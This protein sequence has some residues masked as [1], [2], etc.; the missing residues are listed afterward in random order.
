M[1][2][3]NSRRRCRRHKMPKRSEE[4]RASDLLFCSNLFLR[5]YSYREI[6]QKLNEENARNGM[7]YTISMQ[8][9]HWD[10]QQMLIEWKRERM[11]NIDDY[12]TQELRKLDKMEAELWESWERSKNVKRREK[13]RLG[14]NPCEVP[15]DGDCTEYCEYEEMTKEESAGDPRFLDLLLK[16]QQ[17]RAKMLGIDAPV[18]VDIAGSR[19]NTDSGA[20]GYD[21]SAVPDDLLFAVVDKM[22]S[23]EYK[24][25]LEEK[26]VTDGGTQEDSKSEEGH[27]A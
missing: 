1:V 3:D 23:A 4:Q 26:G 22:Q 14:V 2:S 10:I 24:R 15:N 5:G 12:V 7:G 13:N 16:V 17:R 19:G 21:F 25:L 8:M 27:G 11:D 9:I 18:K 20:P 6:S